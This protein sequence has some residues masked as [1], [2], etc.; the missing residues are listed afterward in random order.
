MHEKVLDGF[1]CE[2]SE[3]NVCL[4]TLTWQNTKIT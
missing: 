2:I 3:S 1:L 4:R